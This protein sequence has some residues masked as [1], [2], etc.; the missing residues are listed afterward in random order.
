MTD[1]QKE[2]I[3]RRLHKIEKR[4]E[5]IHRYSSSLRIK[6]KYDEWLPPEHDLEYMKNLIRNTQNKLEKE[7]QALEKLID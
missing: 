2:G 4:A 1:Q 7:I 3:A 6:L 5:L